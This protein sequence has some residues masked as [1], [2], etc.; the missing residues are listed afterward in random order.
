MIACAK[1]KKVVFTVGHIERYNP[2]IKKLKKVIDAG[3]I[4]DVTS[5]VCRRVGGFPQMEPKLT[6]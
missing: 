1:K 2:L 4:G 6:L 5:I 3:K